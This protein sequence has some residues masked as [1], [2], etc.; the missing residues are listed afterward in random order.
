MSDDDHTTPTSDGDRTEPTPDN[1]RTEPT[2]DNDRTEPTP[3]GDRDGSWLRD[4]TLYAI[5]GLVFVGTLSTS[6]AAPALPGIVDAFSISEARAGLVMT[7]FFAPATLAIPVMG[8]AADRYGR[9][10]VVLASVFVFGV[11]GAGVAFAD[12]FRTVL[13]LRTVQGIAFPGTLPLSIALIGDLYAGR[14]ATTAQGFRVSVN[15]VTG[16]VMPAVAGVAAGLSWRVPFALYALALPAFVLCLIALP[17]STVGGDTPADDGDAPADDGDGATHRPERASTHSVARGATD[18]GVAARLAGARASAVEL[19]GAMT[20][21]IRVLVVATISLFLVRFA[22]LT[23]VPVYLVRTV[24]ASDAVGGIAVSVLGL[25]RFVVAPAAGAVVAR[26]GPRRAVV[27]G[28]AIFA[29]GTVALVASAEPVVVVTLMA[30][31]SVGEGVV[32]PVVNDVVTNE[33]TADVRGRV[34]SALEGGK[35]GAVA[36]SPALFGAVLAATTY[37]TI[38]LA[39]GLVVAASALLVRLG[40]FAE[41]SAG[42]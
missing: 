28:L 24:G 31:L 41:E 9:R 35:S 17:E 13:V 10:P 14:E 19:A 33:A 22:L 32:N 12:A 7:A 20:P 37:R 18:G 40:P 39:G 21:T 38:F 6:L 34:V 5:L 11:A 3:D 1:D 30:L 8:W 16:V 29:T 27:G 42:A 2:P 15:G 23:Y 4:L 26:I 25:G 36:V